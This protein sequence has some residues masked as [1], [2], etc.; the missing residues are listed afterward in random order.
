[1]TPE[2]I[3]ARLLYRDGLMLIIDKPAGLAVHSGAKGGLHLMDLL[4]GLRF[5]LPRAPELAHRLDRD[6]S[7]CLVLGRHRKAL[8]RLGEL[9]AN[10]GVEKVYWA[11]V[12]GNPPADSGTIDKPLKKLERRHGWRMVVDPSGQ[13]S[14]TDWRVLGRTDRLAWI[15]ARP[16]TGRTHQIRVHLASMGCPIVGDSVYGRGTADLVSPD[17]HLHARH[18]SVPLAKGKPPVTATA[19]VPP[20]MRALLTA[21]G[22]GED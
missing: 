9:F 2:D 3:A 1:M 8:A 19:P 11:V 17:L 15:E 5:G 16:R 4:D 20:H 22:C 21:C 6:T 18:I 13:P 12:V 10:G 7:G 14:V